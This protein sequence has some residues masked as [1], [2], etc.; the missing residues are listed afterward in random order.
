MR[1]HASLLMAGRMN[2]LAA[3]LAA[4]LAVL[5]IWLQNTPANA[6]TG[7][8]EAASGP[9][10]RL[11]VFLDSDPKACYAT[12]YEAAIERLASREVERINRAGGV[13]GRPL[14]LR[15]F[16]SERDARRTNANVAAALELEDLLAMV[17]VTSS[18]RGKAVFAGLADGNVPG[19]SDR[20]AASGIPFITDMSVSDVFAGLPNVF[21]TRP[22]QEDGNARIV[23]R[24]VETMGFRNV[25][26]IANAD[27][28]HTKS[29][30]DALADRLG[31]QRVA[32]D[33]RYAISQAA[34]GNGLDPEALTRAV[35]DMAGRA[36]DLVVLAV[37]SS[38]SGP[39]LE[40]LRN[41]G[42]TPSVFVNGALERIP[43]EIRQPYP[44]ALYELTRTDLPELL[45]RRLAELVTTGSPHRWM[46]DRIRNERALGW[47]IGTCK[48]KPD[49]GEPDPLSFE[50]RRIIERG[51]QFADM[52]ALVADTANAA[53]PGSGLA[54]RR[55]AVVRAMTT[56]FA[57][58]RGAFR[59]PYGTWSFDPETRV[60]ER[61]QYLIIYPF[62]Q[63]VRRRQLAPVQFVRLRDRS[64][65]RIDTLYLDIDL[66][67]AHRVDDNEKTFLAEFYLSL[68]ANEGADISKLLFTN[69]FIDPRTNGRQVTIEELH[70]GSEDRAFPDRMKIYRV[71]GQFYFQPDLANY[72]FDTQRFAI[73]IKPKAGTSFLVQPPPEDLRDGDVASDDWQA[74][75]KF[76]GLGAD[77]V[78]VVDAYRHEPAV[79]PFYEAEFVWMMRREARDY[80]LRVIIPLAFILLIAYVSVFIPKG[81]IEAEITIQVT[82]LLSA[83]ALYLSLPQ[84][85]SDVATLSDRLFLFY[86]LLISVMVIVT[87]IREHGF[88]ARRPALR[89]GFG[90]IHILGIPAAVAAMA[91]YVYALADEAGEAF[92]FW[93]PG[94]GA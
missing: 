77:F 41:A 63:E 87:I 83:V 33:A 86:Y 4:L 76:V 14:E 48:E 78:P 22:S 38:A 51:M 28:L 90:L 5:F 92:A 94:F 70:D 39:V 65:R 52:V 32:P 88:I 3:V 43:E 69:A 37:G 54:A 31:P 93:P 7:E 40:A 91:W 74:I 85:D 8:A 60:A 11:A 30:A 29:F 19:L 72:P 36:P 89:T 17:G 59:G 67:R 79:V 82:A 45:D 50:N 46:F 84:L 58:G 13:N 6:L 20:I 42:V 71:A 73:L 9:P 49:T 10:L 57:V 47:D 35:S 34:D 2:P 24:F 25:A 16:D 53:A 55:A 64:L 15:F 68:R 18:D 27:R 81:H 66:I 75:R 62:G 44:N 12:G 61:P 23:A 21:S 80:V 1:C 56:G 26:V